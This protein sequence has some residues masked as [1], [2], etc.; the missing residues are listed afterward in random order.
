MIVSRISRA[1]CGRFLISCSWLKALPLVL[2]FLDGW[3]QFKRGRSRTTSLCCLCLETLDRY[4]GNMPP[5][6]RC[7]MH[8]RAVEVGSTRWNEM[9]LVSQCTQFALDLRSIGTVVGL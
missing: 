6:E 8:T 2:F 9:I 4:I 3:R 1:T 5:A 7:R